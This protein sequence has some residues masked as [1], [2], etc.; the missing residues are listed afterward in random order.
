MTQICALFNW[1]AIYNQTTANSVRYSSWEDYSR[2]AG[3]ELYPTFVTQGNPCPQ[4]DFG[5]PAI[6]CST[7]SHWP[8]KRDTTIFRRC[9]RTKW[10][11]TVINNNNHCRL[12][13]C[14]LLSITFGSQQAHYVRQTTGWWM[15]KY[16]VLYSN[17]IIYQRF[18]YCSNCILASW[19]SKM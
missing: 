16:R 18:F 14:R 15:D 6:H 8:S 9:S 13:S 11:S 1:F 4:S 2:L 7:T 10:L 3:H 12:L 19:C 17:S 5:Y